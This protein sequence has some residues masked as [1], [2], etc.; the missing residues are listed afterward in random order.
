MNLPQAIE[1]SKRIVDLSYDQ[2]KLAN[3]SLGMISF[4]RHQHILDIPD[5]ADYGRN[6]QKPDEN[7]LQ[8]FLKEYIIN[9]INQMIYLNKMLILIKMI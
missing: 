5:A 1:I 4:E 3:W 2:F 6:A 8:S 7:M 9:K